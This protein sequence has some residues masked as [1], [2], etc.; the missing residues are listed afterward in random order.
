M[1]KQKREHQA[2]KR[3]LLVYRS[4]AAAMAGV[5]KPLFNYS[6]DVFD[7]KSAEGPVIVIANHSC[8][9]DPL[10]LAAAF[11]R[12][13]MYYVASEHI[14][15][16]KVFGPVINWLVEPIARKKAGMASGTVRT[17]LRH[18]K[19]GHS[20]AL[21]AEG[22]QTW[23]GIT[24]KV[25]PATGKLVKQSG[26]SLVTYRID[27]AYISLPRWARGIRTGKVE[28]HLVNIYTPAELNAMAPDDIN[29]AINKDI[30]ADV[31]KW[32]DEH[33]E[34]RIPYRMRGKDRGLAEGLDK[35]LYMCPGCGKIGGLSVSGDM[36]FCTCGYCGRY[37]ETGF[38]E[39]SSSVTTIAEWDEWQTSA[40]ASL[41]DE[42]T[43]NASSEAAA[44]KALLFSDTSAQLFQVEDGHRDRKLAEG[45]LSLSLEG[46]DLVMS[47]CGTRFALADISMMAMVLSNI[48]LF[49]TEGGY[50]Q[51]LTAGANL[52]KYLQAW[53]HVSGIQ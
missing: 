52:R 25:F 47:A 17:C 43:R 51:I 6:C 39:G 37:L 10:L 21:F 31:W 13:Q 20:V 40:F 29:E 27:G 16:W 48:L 19:A 4:L 8:A 11:R 32:Q 38:L 5:T 7:P 22:E 34:G 35:A 28:G 46:Q 1:D 15:R 53:Q 23:T 41:L 12:N 3:H 26:A 30:Y 9:W 44:D 45:V 49:R 33:P 18:L 2:R 24:G 42:M 14:L 50:Y 36:I